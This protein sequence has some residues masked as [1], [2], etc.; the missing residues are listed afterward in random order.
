MAAEVGLGYR[1]DSCRA[2]QS[3]VTVKSRLK[4]LQVYCKFGPTRMQSEV[5]QWSLPSMTRFSGRRFTGWADCNLNR[6]NV[7]CP[8][9]IDRDCLEATAGVAHANRKRGLCSRGAKDDSVCS[10]RRYLKTGGRGARIGLFYLFTCR[11][12]AIWSCL[13]SSRD[14]LSQVK[15]P[16]GGDSRSLGRVSILYLALLPGRCLRF[17]AHGAGDFRELAIGTW[18]RDLL[19]AAETLVLFRDRAFPDFANLPASCP[20]RK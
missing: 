3:F 2:Y 7:V 8:G 18:P 10:A 12:L 19:L 20:V 6:A 4:V 17:G 11:L 16:I 1:F 5:F 15:F 14:P 13:L 9:G